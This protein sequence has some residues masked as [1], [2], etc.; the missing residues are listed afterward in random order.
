MCVLESLWCDVNLS[1]HACLR[2]CTHA[3]IALSLSLSLSLAH[4][5]THTH[6]HTLT[7]S[8]APSLPLLAQDELRGMHK[9]A[10]TLMEALERDLEQW[11]TW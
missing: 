7:R 2:T 8:F 4:T 10:C 11:P 5:H 1:I 6:T 9:T 3:C